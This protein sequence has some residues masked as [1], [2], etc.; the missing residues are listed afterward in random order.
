M[1][2][3]VIQNDFSQTVQDGD[4]VFAEVYKVSAVPTLTFLDHTESFTIDFVN[5][6]QVPISHTAQT[7]SNTA[8]FCPSGTTTITATPIQFQQG[9]NQYEFFVNNLSKQGSSTNNVFAY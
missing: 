3:T 2:V 8:I 9:T 1:S 4:Q 6:P 5:T 7:E